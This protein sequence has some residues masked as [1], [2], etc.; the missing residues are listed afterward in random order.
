MNQAGGG[1]WASPVRAAPEPGLAPIPRWRKPA[2]GYD[3][4]KEQEKSK[5]TMNSRKVCV[6]ASPLGKTSMSGVWVKDKVGRFANKAWE[7]FQIL[8]LLFQVE[9]DEME[10]RV[11]LGVRLSMSKS[12]WQG[13][14]IEGTREI[15]KKRRMCKT[16]LQAESIFDAVLWAHFCSESDYISFSHLTA[17]WK[18]RTVAR[19]Y[20]DGHGHL[21]CDPQNVA[22]PAES[23]IAAQQV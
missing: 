23:T 16:D 4:N 5:T 15:W 19:Q 3:F 11:L 13:R 10:A 21:E 17:M 1:G 9:K 18:S 2:Q 20:G 14:Q 8:I 7:I 22:R 6:G 12:F